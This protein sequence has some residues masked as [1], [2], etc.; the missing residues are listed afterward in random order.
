PAKALWQIFIEYDNGLQVWVNLHP[1][2]PWPVELPSPPAWVAY[3]ALVNGQ[4]QD[5][6]S[7]T[8]IRTY[9]LPPNGWVVVAW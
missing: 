4:R 7:E 3:S 1:S 5:G 6:V 9:L 8:G 2:E